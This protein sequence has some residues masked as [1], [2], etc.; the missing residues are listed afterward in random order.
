MG[1]E[2]RALADALGFRVWV[3]I[4]VS[5]HRRKDTTQTAVQCRPL[6]EL[7]GDSDIEQPLNPNSP[8]KKHL[9]ASG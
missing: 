1:A 4:L 3:V 9:V 7:G 8:E 6:R 5:L 2:P